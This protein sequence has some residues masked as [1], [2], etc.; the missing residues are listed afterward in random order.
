MD[1]APQERRVLKRTASTASLSLLTPPR[2]YRRRARGRSRGSCDSDSDDNADN[3]LQRADSSDEELEHE[4]GGDEKRQRKKRRLT[5]AKTDDADE[6]AKFWG[7]G[8]E[9]SETKAEEPKPGMSTRSKKPLLYQRLKTQ[10][11]ASSVASESGSQ[12][13]ASPPPSNRK[14]VTQTVPPAPRQ[15]TPRTTRSK[16][17]L[18][19]TPPPKQKRVTRASTAARFLRDSPSNPFVATPAN[20]DDDGD[21][22]E[23]PSTLTRGDESPTPAYDQKTVTYVF[24]GV[25]RVYQNPMYNH[26]EDRP[27][28][29]PPNSKLPVEHPLY[30]PDP[31]IKPKLLFP[32]AHK[33][34]KGKGKGKKVASPT[35]PTPKRIQDS[36]SE[37]E[38]EGVA[39][40]LTKGR[41]KQPSFGRKP[42]PMTLEAELKK[43]AVTAAK[44]EE[45]D[46]PFA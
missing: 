32:E 14:T 19:V 15:T 39:Q 26:V 24:R 21:V 12:G 31:T 45:E 23:S 17:Y 16:V 4:S 43:A 37:L 46:D 6:E 30:S 27:L 41:L 33:K 25:K 1:A 7:M 40:T 36:E 18:P 38:A 22:V 35:T 10:S 11:V 29:P 20:G 13:L 42:K 5:G 3:D 44:L 28:T 34:R 9:S 8:G 2:T